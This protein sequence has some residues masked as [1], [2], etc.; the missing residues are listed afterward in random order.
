MDVNDTETGIP[1]PLNDVYATSRLLPLR[2]AM[3][4]FSDNL[5]EGHVHEIKTALRDYDQALTQISADLTALR[6]LQRRLQAQRDGVQSLLSPMMQLPNEAL[7]EIFQ[8]LH[9]ESTRLWKYRRTMSTLVLVCVRWKEVIYAA[10]QFWTKIRCTLRNGR[11]PAA[12]EDSLRN[13]LLRTGRLPV[14]LDL[15]FHYCS[16]NF[17]AATIPL[18]IET[19]RSLTLTFSTFSEVILASKLFGS[20]NPS[21]PNLESLHLTFPF[22]PQEAE[23]D[24]SIVLDVTTSAPI[25]RSIHIDGHL[26]QGFRLPLPQLGHIQ[27]SSLWDFGT[28]YDIVSQCITAQ[29]ITILHYP[30]SQF[31]TIEPSISPRALVTLPHVHRL[32]ISPHTTADEAGQEEPDVSLLLDLLSLP[33]LQ[34]FEMQGVY[35]PTIETISLFAARSFS[36]L[37]QLL[38]LDLNL[39]QGWDAIVPLCTNVQVLSLS[40]NEIDVCHLFQSLTPSNQLGVS[41]SLPSLKALNVC[42]GHLDAEVIQTMIVFVEERRGLSRSGSMRTARLLI[43]EV[44]MDADDEHEPDKYEDIPSD[45]LERLLSAKI[46]GLSLTFDQWYVLRFLEREHIY[47]IHGF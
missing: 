19:I 15:S 5:S 47:S 36:S 7:L 13:R 46:Q 35:L 6:T 33:A 28:V 1:M 31:R 41:P 18:H 22:D 4:N 39:G 26:V 25:L 44:C 24:S 3:A 38:L 2:E 17:A 10:P 8:F 45:L 11:D 16:V 34:R 40:N 37:T 32:D 14:D 27:V 21:F 30:T 23:S 9:F 20:K 42:E 43:L 12:F 29:E